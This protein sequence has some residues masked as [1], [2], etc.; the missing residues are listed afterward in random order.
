MNIKVRNFTSLPALKFLG[1]C[2]ALHIWECLAIP[3]YTVYQ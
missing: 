3:T 2:N 1:I